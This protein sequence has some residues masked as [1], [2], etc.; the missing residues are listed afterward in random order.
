MHN[1]RSSQMSESTNLVFHFYAVRVHRY[2]LKEVGGF[3]G[4][5]YSTISVIAKQID[6]RNKPEK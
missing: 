6:E 4:L 1:S 3:V 2:I 5:R